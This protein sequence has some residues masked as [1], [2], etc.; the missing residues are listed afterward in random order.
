MFEMHK[1]WNTKRDTLYLILPLYLF[2]RTCS[3]IPWDETLQ[4]QQ[5]NTA[6]SKS[7]NGHP[8]KQQCDPFPYVIYECLS[9]TIIKA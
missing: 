6:V 3:T 2:S 4:N 7:S 9:L 1:D 8:A 5:Y